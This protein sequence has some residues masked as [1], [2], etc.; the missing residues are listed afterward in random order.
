[1][2]RI[3]VL[4]PYVANQIAA[5][6]VVERPASVLKEALENSLDAGSTKIDITIR[7]GGTECIQI[8]DN[9]CGICK[10]DLH[11]ALAQH[12]TSKIM[13][14]EDLEGILSL[15]FRGEALASI[16]AVSK[17]S[18]SSRTQEAEHGWCIQKEGREADGILMPSSQ[19]LG[20][21]LVIQHLFYNTPARRKF[22]KSEKTEWG[23][24]QETFKRIALSHPEVAF[25]LTEG[26]HLRKRLP[27]CSLMDKNT[28][29]KRVAALC[30]ESFIKNSFYIESENNGLKLQGW[31]GTPDSSRA[32]PDV[33]Y[34]YVNGRI[35]RDKVV[36]H[37]IRQ[38]YQECPIG[39][40]PA[41]VL[42]FTC[43]P[44]SVDVNVHPTKHEVRFREARIIHAFLAYSI[45][46]GLTQGVGKSI[47]VDLK[48]P[49]ITDE[50]GDYEDRRGAYHQPVSTDAL[51]PLAIF[52]GEF[53]L[54]ENQVGLWVADIK[55]IRY[56]A[57]LKALHVGFE[58]QTLVKRPLLLPKIMQVEASL[59]ERV[60]H[61]CDWSHLGFELNQ[62]GPTEI[63]IRAV[64]EIFN[65]KIDHLENLMHT[66]F[67]T[68]DTAER[69]D[70]M[71][72]Y[73]ATDSNFSTLDAMHWLNHSSWTEYSH[74]YKQVSIE[75][76][77]EI[78]YKG[79]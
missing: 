30:G 37:A 64:P 66:L 53:L 35:V 28:H 29:E 67:L 61:L 65:A 5:G 6:E 59:A 39:R 75:T 22:L 69:L 4:S 33:Q 41:Y 45:Q 15:G 36:T 27:A 38:A 12:A 51:K 8:E 76:L 2:S 16:A 42:Y 44:M 34:F 50:L 78:V 25:S 14:S 63:L 11:L 72:H 47:T 56:H 7:R 58:K 19:P 9:G 31:L 48:L 21:R 57:S 70:K 43:D 71:A 74:F 1:M 73:V 62:V 20:T 26:E 60:C 77:R 13:H 40:Y 55:A 54:A 17:V 32:Q 18:L 68:T 49:M 52:A 24:I 10:E 3:H 23:H 46:E 79:V